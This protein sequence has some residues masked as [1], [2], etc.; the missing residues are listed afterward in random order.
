M[1]GL[2][3]AS[4]VPVTLTLNVHGL[5]LDRDVLVNL[6]LLWVKNPK[7]WFFASATPKSGWSDL[8]Q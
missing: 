1:G 3:F 5:T 7:K 6:P 8:R 4:D 2:T